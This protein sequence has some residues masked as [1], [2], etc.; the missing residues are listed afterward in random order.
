LAGPRVA[1]GTHW[2]DVTWG[3]VMPP[4][5]SRC[6]G[7]AERSVVRLFARTRTASRWPTLLPGSPA[8]ARRRRFFS[9]GAAARLATEAQTTAPPVTGPE[10]PPVE[11]V[12]VH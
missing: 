8:S 4:Q 9:T 6:A 5:R 1:C 3:C 2:A 11:L 10:R 12:R 7:R